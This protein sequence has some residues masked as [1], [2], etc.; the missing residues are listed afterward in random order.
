MIGP[1]SLDDQT[2]DQEMILAD[3]SEN[4]KT[5]F[6]ELCQFQ[7]CL[8]ILHFLRLNPTTLLTADDIAYRLTKPIGAIE[9]DLATLAQLGLV[10]TTTVAGITFYRFAANSSQQKLAQ[11]LCA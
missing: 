1:E 10:Q 8:L 4:A 2:L 9:K 5:L 11:E 7:C 3:L 6:A